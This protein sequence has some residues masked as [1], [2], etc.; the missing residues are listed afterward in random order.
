MIEVKQEEDTRHRGFSRNIALKDL[1]ADR[2][3]IVILPGS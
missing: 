3:T 2:K 1:K